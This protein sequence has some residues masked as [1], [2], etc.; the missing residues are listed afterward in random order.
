MSPAQDHCNARRSHSIRT[1]A[2]DPED[3]A[4]P[5]GTNTPEQASNATGHDLEICRMRLTNS[6]TTD[7]PP[8]KM[9]LAECHSRLSMSL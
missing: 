6:E 5:A 1:L 4:D 9:L 8:R 7:A 3:P 2:E